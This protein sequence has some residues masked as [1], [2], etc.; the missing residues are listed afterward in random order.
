MVPQ[1]SDL[2]AAEGALER[3]M[4]PIDLLANEVGREVL[5]AIDGGAADPG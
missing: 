5:A 4:P 1:V 2:E 3:A